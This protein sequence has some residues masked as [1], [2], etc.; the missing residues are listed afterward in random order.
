MI[1]VRIFASSTMENLS[2]ILK[3]ACDDGTIPGAV[4]AAANKS[5][6]LN[7]AATFGKSSLEDEK[8]W[9][10][11]TVMALFSVTKLVTTITTLQLV[12]QG[13]IGLDD[14]VSEILPELT[15]LPVL[16]G[17]EDGKGVL[18]KQEQKMTL[19]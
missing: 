9:E 5:G 3:A 10:L 8:S 15:S 12:E 6:S 13:K 14:D 18:K 4:I 1:A 7:Y 19:R 11:D 17:M 2:N 16:H